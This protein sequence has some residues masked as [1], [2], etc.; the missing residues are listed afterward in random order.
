MCYAIVCVTILAVQVI[1]RCR[2]LE[3]S[4]EREVADLSM[5]DIHWVVDNF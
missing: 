3:G 4:G 2:V 1:E 5:C